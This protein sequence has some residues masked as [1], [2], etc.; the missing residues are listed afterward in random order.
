MNYQDEN[1]DRPGM[2][3]SGSFFI[4]A[5]YEIFFDSLVSHQV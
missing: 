5:L 2:D 3:N 1:S 4:K